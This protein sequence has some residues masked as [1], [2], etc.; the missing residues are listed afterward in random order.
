MK[1]FSYLIYLVVF[2]AGLFAG[3]VD[4]MAGGG[5]LITVPVLLALNLPPKLAFG[6][7]KF[8]S[9][10]GSLTSTILYTKHGLVNL[11]EVISGIIFTIMGASLGTISVR[12]MP[13][14]IL[15]KL[16][17]FILVAMAIYMIW[18]KNLGMVQKQ[19]RLGPFLTFMLL[20]LV[21]GFYDGFFG[22]GTGNFWALGLVVLLGMNLRKATGCTKVMNFTSNFVALCI[23]FQGGMI[24]YKLGLVMASGQLIGAN[25][26]AHMVVKKG[27]KLVRPVFITVVMIMAAYLFY[28]Q[29]YLL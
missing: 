24:N 8:Q 19:K 20:G 9:T 5:G 2:I 22:P 10:F 12:I 27:E 7:N 16:V 15:A 17:P 14:N 4:S 26:G 13:S 6:T 1:E 18:N 3:L 23:F 21:I 11:K 28:K 29:Y 25:V